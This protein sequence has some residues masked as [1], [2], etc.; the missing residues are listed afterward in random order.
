MRKVFAIFLC[1]LSLYFPVTA[2]GQESDQ[3]SVQEINRASFIRQFAG[4][5]LRLWQAPFKVKRADIKWMIPLGA[6]AGALLATDHAV[7]EDFER[8]E[9]LRPASRSVSKAASVGPLLSM[10]AG[11]WA[12]GKL[13]HNSRMAD[14]GNRALQAVAHTNLIILSLKVMTNRERPNK[15]DGQG[16]FWGGG[17]SFPSGHSANSWAFATVVANEYQD[18]KLVAIGAYSFATAVSLSRIAGQHHFP[19][20]TLVGAA[21]G[22]LV[23]KYIFRRR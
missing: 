13:T 3:E 22:H 7:S 14:T 8:W 2:F 9:N 23:G 1:S 18:H 21:V 11:M 16:Q 12:V 6:A 19:S 15:V 10:T 20:D 4:D 17:R 5:E